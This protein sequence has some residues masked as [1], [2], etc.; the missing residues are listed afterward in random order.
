MD[1]V[2]V[3]LLDQWKEVLICVLLFCGATGIYKPDDQ[4]LLM[5]GLMVATL[6]VVGFAH[7]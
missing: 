7:L 2:L 4:F 6:S 5:L 3:F 1:L